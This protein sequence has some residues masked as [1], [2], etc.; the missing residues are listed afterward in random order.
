MFK[1]RLKGL[2]AMLLAGSIAASAV[3]LTA[4]ARITNATV[5]VYDG[6]N[7]KQVNYLSLQD[8]DLVSHYLT[9]DNL[10]GVYYSYN[11]IDSGCTPPKEFS[12]TGTEAFSGDKLLEKIEGFEDD[13]RNFYSD[14]RITAQ[15]KYIVTTDDP[16]AAVISAKSALTTSTFPVEIPLTNYDFANPLM[17]YSCTP[18]YS[19]TDVY[20]NIYSQYAVKSTD[21]PVRF[22]AGDESISIGMDTFKGLYSA[23]I[24]T[25]NQNDAIEI[26]SKGITIFQL[27]A[28]Y[29]TLNIPV[30]NGLG[31]QQ[32]K[33]GN[34]YTLSVT[35]GLSQ[36]DYLENIS[37]YFYVGYTNKNGEVVLSNSYMNNKQA[38]WEEIEAFANDPNFDANKL[39]FLRPLNVSVY[40]DSTDIGSFNSR[41]LLLAKNDPENLP[42]A[43][44]YIEAADDNSIWKLPLKFVPGKDL[45]TEIETYLNKVPDISYFSLTETT[46]IM[47]TGTEPVSCEINEYYE[48]SPESYEISPLYVET[49]PA[50]ISDHAAVLE[51]AGALKAGNIFD[52]SGWQ[53]WGCE[54]ESGG[55]DGKYTIWKFKESDLESTDGVNSIGIDQLNT[56]PVRSYPL[57][58][59]PQVQIAPSLEVTAPVAG[60]TPSFEYKIVDKVGGYF[61]ASVEWSCDNTRLGANDKFKAGKEYKVTVLLSPDVN[62]SFTD[63]T[64]VTFNGNAATASWLDG[65]CIYS[66]YTFPRTA[67]AAVAGHSLVLEDSIGVK[68][69]MEF[70]DKLLSDDTA[71]MTFTVNGKQ[72]AIPVSEGQRVTLNDKTVYAFTCYVAAAEMTDQITAQ[73]TSADYSSEEFTY[74]VQEYAPFILDDPEG[75]NAKYIP[76]VKAMLNYGAAAQEYFGHNKENL[77][78][79]ILDE[80]DRNTADVTL[81]ELGSYKYIYIDDDANL[82]FNGYQVSL[83]SRITAKFYFNN[84]F[85]MNEVTVLCGKQEVDSSRLSIGSDRNGTY[86]AISDINAGDLDMRFTISVGGI[87]INNFSVYSYLHHCVKNNLTELTALVNTLY[88][89]NEAVEAIA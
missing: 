19:T 27:K 32:I 42:E 48:I 81:S 20:G 17:D 70:S 73:V 53:L 67:D 89:Y 24:H 64:I 39:F 22:S 63:D 13:Y 8:D 1:K 57:I 33:G 31:K 36:Y 23:D 62:L 44:K 60:E 49:V 76:A 46:G 4:S 10:W 66:Y 88:A 9:P 87:T 75:E 2:L 7:K 65:D 86:L 11:Y 30:L 59:I 56:V 78:N 54:F 74:S 34:P 80:G 29:K 28:E 85:T 61:V 77:A 12:A 58:Y 15:H 71:K 35:G 6:D 43:Y 72:T 21:E 26:F 68:F 83:E 41:E 52:T 3:P 40:K 5:N 45:L 50:T 38:A 82:D 51:K 84:A 18:W 55:I 47:V 16:S 69:Y 37:T 25:A 14:I 79:S